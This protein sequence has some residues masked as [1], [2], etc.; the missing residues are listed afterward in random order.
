MTN[1]RDPSAG[2]ID[3]SILD[4]LVA[5]AE[6]WKLLLITSI[7][8]GIAVSGSIY[9]SR[10]AKSEVIYESTATVRVFR[11]EETLVKYA[12]ALVWDAEV[13]ALLASVESDIVSQHQLSELTVA[14]IGESSYYKLTITQ[15]EKGKSKTILDSV[16]LGLTT[17]QLSQV[18]YTRHLDEQKLQI[19]KDSL[20]HSLSIF[21]S[22]ESGVVLFSTLPKSNEAIETQANGGVLQTLT[23]LADSIEARKLN[24]LYAEQQ[25]SGVGAVLLI[26]SASVD[27]AVPLKGQFT[28]IRLGIL[29]T[30]GWFVMMTFFV[31]LRYLWKE[32]KRDSRLKNKI[33]RI[34]NA[35]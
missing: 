4:L 32:A 28:S 25:L 5:I 34:T 17:Q 9:I 8:M 21:E 23:D 2:T 14:S 24:V 10:S 3:I 27:R 20:E 6:S 29:A 19:M 15:A 11:D 7:L 22:F 1:S 18:G 16:L 31:F 33:E 13:S 35:F 12:R 30:I 26:Q